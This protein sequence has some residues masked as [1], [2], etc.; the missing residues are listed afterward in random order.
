M[1]GWLKAKAQKKINDSM[2]DDLSRFLLSLQ[3][4]TSEELATLLVIATTIRLK[5]LQ[6]GTISESALDL[7]QYKGT[8]EEDM[9]ALKINRLISGFQKA[10][11]PS[12]AAGAMVWLHSVRALQTPE[13]RLLGRQMWKE[14]TRGLAHLDETAFELSMI[15][16]NIPDD[17]ALEATFVP[18]GL[19][20][21]LS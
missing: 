2:R 17:V 20:P 19:E 9:A 15:S 4:S 5:L 21:E 8:F 18:V 7:S 13:L 12:D 6:A 10:G 3:G 14:L 16:P 1:F 11:Q